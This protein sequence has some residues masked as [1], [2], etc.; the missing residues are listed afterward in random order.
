MIKTID[1]TPTWSAITPF[2]L[3]AIESNGRARSNTEIKQ[4]L[5]RMAAL[6]DLWVQHCKDCAEAGIEPETGRIL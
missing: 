1:M 3:D 2:L 4:E 5:C 6:A